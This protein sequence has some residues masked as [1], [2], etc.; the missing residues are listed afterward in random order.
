VVLAKVMC[1]D[2]G[3]G[4]QQVLLYVGDEQGDVF[5]VTIAGASAERR[6]VGIDPDHG[7][8]TAECAHEA[9]RDVRDLRIFEYVGST[10]HQNKCIEPPLES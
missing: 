8:V 6:L 10:A 3:A 2:D 1:D 5:G 7:A 9:P 4:G